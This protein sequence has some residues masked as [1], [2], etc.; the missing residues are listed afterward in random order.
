GRKL[1]TNR[2]SSRPIL[3][4]RPIPRSRQILGASP[5][6]GPGPSPRPILDSRPI[7]DPAATLAA[8]ATWRK[9]HAI[10]DAT[11][12]ADPQPRTAADAQLRT[13]ADPNATRGGPSC[14]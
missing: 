11:P 14:P 2:Y 13:A 9:R 6:P 12:G 1:T 10:P 3:D 4:V 8:Q 5:I 7:P